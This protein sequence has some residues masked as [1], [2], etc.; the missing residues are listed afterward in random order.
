M[1]LYRPPSEAASLLIQATYGCP[2]NACTF[3]G[4]YKRSKFRTR[5]MAEI[6]EDIDAAAELY[7]EAVK[8]VFLPDGNTIILS[9]NKLLTILERIAER[10]PDLERVTCY[11]SARYVIKKSAEDLET[12]RAAGLKRIHMGMESGDGPTLERIKKGTTPEEIIAAGRRVKEAGIEISEYYLVGL[13]GTDRAEA[14]ARES[15]RVLNAIEPDFVR[16]RTLVIVP[17]TPLGEEARQGTFTLPGTLD[18]IAELRVLVK[19]L[20]CRTLLLSDHISNHVD[21]NG[22]FPEDKETLL[23]GLDEFLEMSEEDFGGRPPWW[24]L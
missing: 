18:C 14:H 6:I 13:G 7:G 5:P 22:R 1:P 12:L 4:M 15:A 9:T 3:C 17:G 21:L 23:A 20:D 19:H 10:F 16:L 2:H 11:G 8:T 24:A